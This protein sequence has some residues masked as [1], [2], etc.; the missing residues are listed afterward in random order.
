MDIEDLA[1]SLPAY[2]APGEKIKLFDEIKKFK[3][4]RSNTNF[5]ISGNTYPDEILQG[6]AWGDINYI[7]PISG[8]TKTVKGL[9]IS[10]SCDVSEENKRDI[11]LN[12]IFSP[13]LK[14]KN[15]LQLIETVHGIQRAIEVKD[16]ITN[17][18]LSQI[19][20]FPPSSKLPVETIAL[21]DNLVSVPNGVVKNK[22]SEKIHCLSQFGFYLFVIKLSI[23][24]T[25]FN[26]GISRFE[27]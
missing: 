20:Y 8:N 23:H 10:N 12:I 25:R 6:D 5:F 27:S 7:D 9:I 17:H 14:L 13:L 2:L 26:E 11:P 19:V 22:T 1:G 3:E 18:R 4:S 24:F 15:Y 21:L 16:K